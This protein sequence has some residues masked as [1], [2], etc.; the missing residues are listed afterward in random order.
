MDASIMLHTIKEIQCQDFLHV[1][2]VSTRYTFRADDGSC[3][4]ITVFGESG[5]EAA[6]PFT[7]LEA[8]DYRG[9]LA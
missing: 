7:V 1:D 2:F 5:T 8:K 6:V 4:G 3:L 9:E